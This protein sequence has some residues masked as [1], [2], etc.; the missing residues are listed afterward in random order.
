MSTELDAKRHLISP[1][2]SPINDYVVLSQDGNASRIEGGDPFWRL[3]ETE[4]D[5][6]GRQW[7]LAEFIFD[8]DWP[9]WEMHPEA[10]ELVYV[11]SGE[12]NILLERECGVELVHVVAPGLVRVP[13]GIWHTAKIIQPSR[14]LH[15]TMGAGTVVRPA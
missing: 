14:F 13:R 5:A 1:V 12:A 9:N 2:M 3:P 6:V 11:L 7:L 8:T 15:M 10:D 4:L